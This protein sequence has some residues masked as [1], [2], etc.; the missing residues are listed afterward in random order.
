L[1][2]TKSRRRRRP[3][4]PVE[5]AQSP[6]SELAA[7]LGSDKPASVL[8]LAIAIARHQW[9]DDPG[10]SEQRK[11][12]IATFQEQTAAICLDLLISYLQGGRI[13]GQ[14]FFTR[15]PID[16]SIPLVRKTAG[17]ALLAPSEALKA[18]RL[19]LA[20]A[21]KVAVADKNVDVPPKPIPR[22]RAQE[23]EILYVLKTLGFDPKALPAP[24]PGK[25]SMAKQ[26][27]RKALEGYEGAVFA[28]AWLRLQQA[29]EIKYA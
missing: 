8:E 14:D 3:A 20:G 23:L 6:V 24:L 19:L 28:K 26:Q 15:G 9:P 17:M 10:G 29:G 4:R 7:I 18:A 5:S 2:L 16:P 11:R 25:A 12:A 22:W 21:E 27:V 1:D 13:Q